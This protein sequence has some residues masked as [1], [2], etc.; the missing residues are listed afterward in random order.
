M[1][2]GLRPYSTQP[3]GAPQV[4]PTGPGPGGGPYNMPGQQHD[5]QHAASGG[6]HMQMLPSA[7]MRFGS[8]QMPEAGGYPPTAPSL[9]RQSSDTGSQGTNP[10]LS[11]IF[12]QGSV[13]PLHAGI[14][15]G[16][17]PPLP[18]LNLLMCT[19]AQAGAPQLL[20]QQAD[21]Q[22]A[23]PSGPSSTSGMCMHRSCMQAACI[24][25]TYK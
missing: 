23:F 7:L 3:Y 18:D 22:A 1:T 6:Q 10:V 14:P 2:Q 25:H 15:G 4:H 20:P 19:L 17:L 21:A 9:N 5:P 13:F 16:P 8:Q 11:Q 12:G 24:Q